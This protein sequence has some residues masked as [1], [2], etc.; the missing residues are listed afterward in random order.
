M[1]KTNS[2]LIA[3]CLVP[4]LGAVKIKRLIDSVN[5]TEEIFSRSEYKDIRSSE[6]VKQELEYIRDN[7]IKAI[8]ICDD[9]YPEALRNIYDPPVVL[10]VKGSIDSCDINSVGIVGARKCSLYGMRIAEKLGYDLASRDITVVSGLANGI[11]ASSHRGALKAAGRTI[12]VMGSG[13]RHIYPSSSRR[14]YEDIQHHGAVVTEYTSDIRPDRCTFPRRNRIISALSKGI[15]VV[16]AAARSGALITS[17][18]ALEHGKE[19]FAVPGHIDSP[20]SAGTNKLIQ[21]GAKLVIRVEDILEEL[22]IETV[23]LKIKIKNEKSKINEV[24]SRNLPEANIRDLNDKEK[25]VI[26][27]ID[28]ADKVHIDSLMEKSGIAPGSLSKVMLDLELKGKI[29]ALA[30]KEYSLT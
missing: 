24:S 12:A 18:C 20:S 29:K 25:K 14:V 22:N 4:G 6:E 8:T 17:N 28:T 5:D 11:D 23:E 7:D 19:V 27:I 26:S 13:F 15:V 10:F 1:K 21:D 3:L 9:D 30:G 2:D 16:E